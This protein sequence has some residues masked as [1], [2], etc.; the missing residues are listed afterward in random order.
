M[1]GAGAAKPLVFVVDDDPAILPLLAAVLEP[2]VLRLEGASGGQEALD[3]IEA[4]L[5]PDLLILDVMMPAMGGLQ[6]LE[7][8]KVRPEFGQ[9]PVILLTARSRSED[10]VAGLEAGATD[11][12]IKPFHVAELRARVRS[13]LRLRS[14]FLELR[15]AREAALHQERL[16]VLV[17]T[18]GGIAHALNQPLTAAL[19]K[20]EVLLAR[21][22]E[23]S[24]SPGEL[25]F[26]LG[27]VE[28]VAFEV[29]RIQHITRY[30][31]TEYLAGVDILDLEQP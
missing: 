23:P 3:R 9:V 21:R 2:E 27:A 15:A 30:Q 29:R 11:Y 12:V 10:L 1:T 7:R 24:A 6:V 8:L 14:L 28:K 18:T 16:R 17:E 13:A 20:L 31:T 25:E 22:A 19:L 26:L 4:G 5:S